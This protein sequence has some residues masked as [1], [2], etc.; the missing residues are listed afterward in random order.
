MRPSFWLDQLEPLPERPPLP[1]DRRAGVCIVGGG[2][3]G[4]W[5]AYELR[6]ADPGL[7]VVVLEA[8]YAGFGASGRNGGWVYG[9][10]S[11]SPEAWRRRGGPDGPRSMARAMQATVGEIGRV[12]GA[13][14]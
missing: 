10:V 7:E 11:G 13:E 9:G 6:R 4:L 3:T 1:G 14:S 5:P 12:I 8:R 2:F